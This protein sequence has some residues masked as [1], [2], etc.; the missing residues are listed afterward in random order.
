MRS[1]VSF[2]TPVKGVRLGVGASFQRARVYAVSAAGL[3]VWRIGSTLMLAGLAIW[4]IASRD[5]E[6]RLNENYWLVIGLVLAVRYIFKLAVVAAFPPIETPPP[7]RS[8]Q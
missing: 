6:G 7:A 3:K 5:Q 8:A 1:W 2:R 4:L